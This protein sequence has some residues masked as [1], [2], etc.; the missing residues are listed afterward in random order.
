MRRMQPHQ[1]QQLDDKEGGEA[2]VGALAREEFQELIVEL[3]QKRSHTSI[4][5]TVCR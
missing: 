3:A 5:R 2:E 4:P 1:D